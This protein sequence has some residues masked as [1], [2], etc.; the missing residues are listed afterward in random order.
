MGYVPSCTKSSITLDLNVA[1][2][3]IETCG[4]ASVVVELEYT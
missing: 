3:K 2:K 1:C 4:P